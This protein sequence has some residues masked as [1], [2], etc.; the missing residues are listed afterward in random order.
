[1]AIIRKGIKIGTFDI[2]FGLPRDRGFDPNQA[3]KIIQTSRPS[4]KSTISK[5]RSMVSSGEGLARQNKF[6]VVV[7]FPGGL[8]ESSDFDGS[9][10]AEY[11]TAHDFTTSL[12]NDLKER[13]FFFC[14]GASMP[15]RTIADETNDVL[16]G[17]VAQRKYE[18]QISKF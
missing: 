8:L 1:M 4:G 7:N 17:P 12:K 3:A 2:R 16:Y 6:I 14:E 5:F 18:N 13:L 15:G 11:Q 9:E 10:F